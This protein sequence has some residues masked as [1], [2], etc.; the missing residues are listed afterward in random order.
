MDCSSLWK[1]TK[2]DS[3]KLKKVTNILSHKKVERII[4]FIRIQVLEDLHLIHNCGL[5]M[6]VHADHVQLSIEWIIAST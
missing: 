3:M 2:L 4:T 1:S 5:L 6:M